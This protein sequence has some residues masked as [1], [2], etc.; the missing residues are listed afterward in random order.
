MNKHESA[1]RA[2]ALVARL[3]HAQEHSD[4]LIEAAEAFATLEAENVRLKTRLADTDVALTGCKVERDALMASVSMIKDL[5]DD[6]A[7]FMEHL[8]QRNYDA[9]GDVGALYRAD[10]EVGEA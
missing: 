1:I 2:A 6:D 4:L 10:R 7:G 9:L 3:R 5:A 8:G